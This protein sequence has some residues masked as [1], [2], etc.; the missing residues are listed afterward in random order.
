MFSHLI[1]PIDPWASSTQSIPVAAQLAAAAGASVDVVAVTGSYQDRAATSEALADAVARHGPLA[2]EPTQHV[3]VAASVSAAIAARLAD[4]PGAMIVMN[5]H[6][7]GRSAAVLG[8]TATELLAATRAPIVVVGPE[9]GQRP[10]RVDGSY[11]VPLD[12]SEMSETI[13][14]T[15]LDWASTFG[16]EPWLVEVLDPDNELP[17]DVVA[18][19]GVSRCAHD[20]E[21]DLGRVVNYEALRGHRA[22]AT[23]VDF[24]QQ[25]DASLIFMTTHGRTGAAR[26][27]AG[28]VAANVVR[29][30]PCP[31]VML[32]PRSL[33]AP[34]TSPEPPTPG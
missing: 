5:S 33:G 32:R 2:V 27:R 10:A 18:T 22:G 23:I 11:V 20:L 21:R 12:G 13:L 26:L 16:G 19:A 8:S 24:A 6:G 28:S 25:Y 30:A 1:V 4:T 15:V 9:A 34:E 14:P 17:S 7:R 31:V 29:H 3:V